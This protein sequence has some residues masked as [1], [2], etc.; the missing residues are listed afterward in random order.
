MTFGLLDR[1][2]GAAALCQNF[3]PASGITPGLARARQSGDG[4][5]RRNC[6]YSWH[7]LVSTTETFWSITGEYSVLYFAKHDLPGTRP[8]ELNPQL[9][10]LKEKGWVVS[11]RRGFTGVNYSF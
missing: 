10:N 1:S 8:R 5:P 9:D 2:G 4:R 7:D 3:Q 6:F 11:V